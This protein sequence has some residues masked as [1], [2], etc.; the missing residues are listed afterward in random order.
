MSKLIAK[1]IKSK[2]APKT[3]QPT[4]EGLGVGFVKM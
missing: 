3:E 1:Y 4:T 2:Q